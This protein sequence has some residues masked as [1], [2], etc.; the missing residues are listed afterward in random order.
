MLA[1]SGKYDVIVD[2]ISSSGC[3]KSYNWSVKVGELPKDFDFSATPLD[4]CA[5]TPFKFTYLG[6]DVTGFKW[7][8]STGDSVDQSGFSKNF[9]KNRKS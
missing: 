8:F 6:P 4:T 3:N 1:D 5:S 2:I 9:K 7:K